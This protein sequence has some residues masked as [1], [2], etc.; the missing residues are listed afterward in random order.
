LAGDDLIRSAQFSH[1]HLYIRILRSERGELLLHL[2]QR[3][4]LV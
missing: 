2:L 3:N 4:A 1:R